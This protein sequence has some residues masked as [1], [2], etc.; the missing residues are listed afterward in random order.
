MNCRGKEVIVEEKMCD[1]QKHVSCQRNG[2]TC[3]LCI[4]TLLLEEISDNPGLIGYDFYDI[5]DTIL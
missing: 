1:W 2:K 5:I 4:Q 3:G